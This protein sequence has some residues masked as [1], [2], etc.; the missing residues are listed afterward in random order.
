MI[1]LAAI[2]AA[3]S[4]A[5]A[6]PPRWLAV[7]TNDFELISTG[8]EIEIL[9][10]AR[11]IEE[12]RDLLGRLF[13]R[14]DGKHGG[15]YF[16]RI[17]AF[18]DPASYAAFRPRR[19]DRTG[20]DGVLGYF[21]AGEREGYITIAPRSGRDAAVGTVNHELF[22]AFAR[23]LLGERLPPWL[24]EG[25]AEYFETAR[26]TAA[27]RTAVLG[28]P[29]ADHLRLLKKQPATDLALVAAV[30]GP[31][32]Q[33]LTGAERQTFYARSWLAVHYLFSTGRM[34]ADDLAA[35]AVAAGGAVDP[36][37][38]FGLDRPTLERELA[39]HLARTASLRGDRRPAPISIAL[40]PR[41]V[42][43]DARSSLAAT[44]I[45]EADANARLGALLAHL[46]DLA[47]AE[48]VLR[49]SLAAD[50]LSPL[51]N[52]SLGSLLLRL[53]RPA[54]A[55]PYLERA[56]EL[57]TS[58]ASVF[59]GHAYAL[60]LVAAGLRGSVTRFA[61]DTAAKMRSS[62]Q[63][64]IALAPDSAESYRLLAFTYFVND[65]DRAE[66]ERLMRR[67]VELQPADGGYRLLL[68][69]ILIV[70]E[71]YDE[72]RTIASGLAASK[73]AGVRAPAEE[74][75]AAVREYDLA[76][77]S[78]ERSAPIHFRVS[79]FALPGIVVLKRSWLAAGDLELI[80]RFRENN[81][82][83]RLLIRPAADEKQIVG[84]IERVECTPAGDITYLVAS[85]SD[86]GR[87]RL[88]SRGFQSL[89]MTVLN[90]GEHSF[91]IGCGAAL[92]R[93]LAV[94]NV[95]SS[96]ADSLDQRPTLTA[97]S[98][99]PEFFRLM[100]IGELAAAKTVVV[101]DDDPRRSTPAFLP[102]A[103][104]IV[105]ISRALRQPLEGELRV[106]GSIDRIECSAPAVTM[107]VAADGRTLRLVSETPA[108]I[109]FGWFSVASSQ[110]PLDCGG[111]VDKA[112]AVVTYRP[113]GE[114]GRQ[115]DGE[116]RAIEFVPGEFRF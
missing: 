56:V 9:E 61:G 85:A 20:D 91:E 18:R 31:A 27:G 113:L 98:F 80:E 103:E 41:D 105:S 94:L 30:D 7:R 115:Y 84:R 64:A 29:L 112:K 42:A 24:S 83:N 93:Q 75:L 6:Q 82:V 114:A 54:A 77:A 102:T 33:R 14:G 100:S 65:D 76:R 81:N 5:F 116:I 60:Q 68:A 109:V 50:P 67:A 111:L 72:A 110:M 39:A 26:L 79:H 48:G 46:G 59:F 32:L 8:T 78:L 34:T 3:A 43:A 40:R 37:S 70:R 12:F 53:E 92:G 51:A 45:T 1:L 104:R 10:M 28:E 13:A 55:L 38:A 99:V 57:G 15:R 22:H 4:A 16:L 101:A 19:P 11:Q 21:A 95:R 73:D 2:L 23:E 74:L 52:G 86:G 36:I 108:A 63:K 106:V 107:N 89:R 88:T 62:L 90:E 69:R 71:K 44:S 87:I 47:A 25:L 96:A 17:V 97:I 58:D 35:K 49:Q 66:A